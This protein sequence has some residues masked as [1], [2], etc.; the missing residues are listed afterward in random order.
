MMDAVRTARF[1]V[2]KDVLRRDHVAVGSINSPMQCML[3]R[4]CSQCLQ[5]HVY[6]VTGKESM[7]FSCFNQDQLLDRGDFRFLQ[8]ACVRTP[9]PRS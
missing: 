2:L 1:T 7:V 9:P 8:S 4:V 5:R 3:K 6:P